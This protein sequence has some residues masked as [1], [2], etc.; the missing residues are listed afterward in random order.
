LDDPYKYNPLVPYKGDNYVKEEKV[1]KYGMAKVI[2]TES[3]IDF[4]KRNKKYFI[5]NGYY[6]SIYN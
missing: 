1:I 2:S 5:D 3:I 6:F 4:L